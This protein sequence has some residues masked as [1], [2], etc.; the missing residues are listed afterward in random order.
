MLL[1]CLKSLS[2][3]SLLAIKIDGEAVGGV[4]KVVLSRSE[5]MIWRVEVRG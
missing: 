2:I 4:E 1:L 3:Y 5:E